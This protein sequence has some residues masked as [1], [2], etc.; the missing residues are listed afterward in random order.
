M[1]L[2]VFVPETLWIVQMPLSTYGLEVGTRMTVC[3]LSSGNLW[4]HSPIRPNEELR[5]QLDSLGTVRFVIAPVRQHHFFID[6]FVSAYPDTL[7]FGSP[8]LP[9]KLPD[10]HFDGVLGSVPAPEWDADIDQVPIRGNLF[11]D[12][13]VFFHR[14]SHTLIVADLCICGYQ[15]QPWFTR[16]GLWLAGVYQKPGP[17]IDVKLAYTDKSAARDSLEKVMDWDFDKMILSHGH[18]I[19]SDAKKVFNQAYRFLLS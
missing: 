7:L 3:R 14:Q 12:E 4:V 17:M 10:L 15:E 2:E 5:Q 16:F 18:L 6:D 13:V 11:H 8:D 19:Y 9:K 1:K